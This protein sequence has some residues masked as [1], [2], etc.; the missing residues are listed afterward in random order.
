[1][2]PTLTF[3]KIT[4]SNIKQLQ[5]SKIKLEL[6]IDIRKDGGVESFH[7]SYYCLEGKMLNL[8]QPF[9]YLSFLLI[10]ESQ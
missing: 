3:L 4:K 7:R 10:S 6:Q 1:M 5:C 9:L 2:Y 8:F